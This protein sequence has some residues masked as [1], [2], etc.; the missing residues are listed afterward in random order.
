M[1]SSDVPGTAVLLPATQM[2]P[3]DLLIIGFDFGTGSS[4][5]TAK[6]IYG[7]HTRE[8]AVIQHIRVEEDQDLAIRQ[9]MILPEDGN[10]VYGNV[11]VNK[12]VQKKE[13]LRSRTMRR[14]KLSLHPGFERLPDVIHTLATIFAEKDRAARQDLFEDFLRALFNDVRAA[15]KKRALN[16]GQPDAYRDAIP[17]E[18]HISAPAM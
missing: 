14:I 5:T 17:L 13:S 11:D 10:V 18:I 9:I 15:H 4:R 7:I 6:H 8:S 3:N 12:A 1:A 16:T 2:P